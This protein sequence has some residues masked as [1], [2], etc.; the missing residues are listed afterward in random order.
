MLI[1]QSVVD[2]LMFLFEEYF[3]DNDSDDNDAIDERNQIQVRL[4]EVGFHH[5]EINQAFNW[6][7]DLATLRENSVNTPARIGSV[8]IFSEVEK[9][10]L[11]QE[12]LS[13]ILFLE[14]SGILTPVTRELVLDRITALGHILD[15]EQFKWIVM[16]VLH[17]HPGEENAFAWM[18]SLVFNEVTDYIQ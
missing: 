12:C 5:Q 3:G 11:D 13:F 18:E 7:E 6:L 1:K 2:V 9:N 10:I 4:E 8:R 17:T 16:I 15:I 14:Q